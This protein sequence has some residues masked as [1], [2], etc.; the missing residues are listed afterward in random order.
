MIDNKIFGYF[1]K[2]L[3]LIYLL[4]KTIRNN[5]KSQKKNLKEKNVQIIYQVYINR[6]IKYI[7]LYLSIFHIDSNT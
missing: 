5:L 4:N 1:M 2:I 7:A 3:L 6:I